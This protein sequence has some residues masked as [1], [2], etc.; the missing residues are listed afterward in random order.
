MRCPQKL[1]TSNINYTF[2][3]F[4]ADIMR[5]N[6][7][8][9]VFPMETHGGQKT[10]EKRGRRKYGVAFALSFFYFQILIWDFT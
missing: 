7:V 1:K 10:R 9:L 5:K 3:G 2:R 6:M 4:V 8:G